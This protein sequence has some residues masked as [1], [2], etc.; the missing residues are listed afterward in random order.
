MQFFT[1]AT[2]RMRITS[3]G[4]V[5][6]NNSSPQARLDLGAGYGSNGEK[7]FVYND[8]NTSALSGTKM[9]FYIDRF[10]ESNSISFVFP[11]A[12]GTTSRYHVAYKN[13]GNTTITDVCYVTYNSTSWAFPSDERLKDIEGIIPNALD[14][15]S[16]LRAVYYTQKRDEQKKRKVGL[17]AQDLLKV[18]PEVVDVPDTELDQDG[19][20]RYM[21]VA[22]SDTIPLLVK[23]IQEQTDIINELKARIQTL[24]NK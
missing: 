16:Q 23:A 7:F 18:L 1:S 6:I 5:G 3:G 17:L 20:Q 24:E 11:Y 14:K 15:I 4:L 12:S 22:L 19:N 21:S 10:S 2:E 9:G 8:D 13:T